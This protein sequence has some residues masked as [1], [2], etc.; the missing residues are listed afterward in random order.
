MNNI[1]NGDLDLNL[2]PVFDALIRVRNVSRAAEELD[3]SQSAVSHA[4]KRLRLFFGDQLFLKTGSG[5]QPTPRALELLAPVLAVMG[6][7]RS[8][9]LVHEG[10]DAAS[11]RRV[12]SLCLTDMGELIFL[13]RLIERLRAAAPGCTLRTLQ[14]PMAT[15]QDVLESGEADLALGS[16]HSVPEGLFQQQLFT[17]SF[18]TIVSRRNRGIGDAITREQFLAMEHIVVSLSG[19]VEDGYDSIVDQLA[20]P[21]RVYLTTPHFL[22]VPM[23]IEQNPELIATVPR[24]LATRFANYKSIKAVETPIDVPPFAIRQHWH[25]R[26]QHDAANV[27]LRKQVKEVFDTHPE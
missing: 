23:I 11:S 7:V 1:H 27:W 24:E 20:G 8:E 12:F 13:P 4:L 2:L 18:V 26:F 6:T 15:I 16:L 21:R 5:M 25:P 22:T 14:V 17:R 10:F 3:M 19:R 9:L